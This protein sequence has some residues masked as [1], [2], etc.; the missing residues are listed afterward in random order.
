[1]LDSETAVASQWISWFAV[2]MSLVMALVILL[3]FLSCP[4][5]SRPEGCS[6]MTCFYLFEVY[7]KSSSFSL[8]VSGERA[9][10]G[11]IF[12]SVLLSNDSR[13]RNRN[14][15]LESCHQIAEKTE[16]LQMKE[17]DDPKFWVETLNMCVW[18]LNFKIWLGGWSTSIRVFIPFLL[19]WSP[20][21]ECSLHFLLG[22]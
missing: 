8:Q 11:A 21:P 22:G 17:G 15:N 4:H 9:G 18:F 20:S 12:F 10:K 13:W 7:I 3:N 19:S 14:F 6:Y 5:S 1:M 2:W 16:N